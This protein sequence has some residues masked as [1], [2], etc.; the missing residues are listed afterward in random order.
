MLES[1]KIA[2]DNTVRIIIYSNGKKID[3]SYRIVS[4]AIQKKINTIPFAK[5]VLLDGDIAS[6]DFPI[7]D[8]DDFKPGREIKIEVGYA[9]QSE[10]VFEGI[11]IKHGIKITGDNFSRLVVEARDKAVKMTI[12]R[13]NANYVDAKDSDVIKKLIGNYSGLKADVASTDNKY[14]ELVQYYCSD[15]DYMLSRAETNGLWV[16]VDDAN[17]SVQSPQ[18]KKSG[19]SCR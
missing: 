16:I 10:T 2:G 11:I 7:S 1:P 8:K 5:I 4:V 19:P 15:W 14:E 13:K 18:K 3:E 9:N 17:V 6:G 12:G